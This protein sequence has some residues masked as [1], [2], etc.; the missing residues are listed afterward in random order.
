MSKVASRSVA[1]FLVFLSLVVGLVG[2]TRGGDGG[3]TKVKLAFRIVDA[4]TGR[5]VP[6]ADVQIR[7]L[8]DN[9]SDL[10]Y[11]LPLI[12]GSTGKDGKVVLHGEFKTSQ[13]LK[14]APWRQRVQFDHRWLS[15]KALGYQHS[16]HLLDSFTGESRGILQKDPAEAT[17]KLEPGETPDSGLETIAD[18]YRNEPTSLH[19]T[20]S[21]WLFGDG[22]FA[23]ALPGDMGTSG[24]LHWGGA[25]FQ[26][27]MVEL[28][29]MGTVG[30]A[31]AKL[32][33]EDARFIPVAWG[34]RHYLIEPFRMPMFCNE[35]NMGTLMRPG[36]TSLYLYK[37]SEQDGRKVH[38]G[39]PVL[40]T[41][42]DSWI[43]KSPI[44]GLVLEV[45]GPSSA[46]VNLGVKNGVWKGMLLCFLDTDKKAY[47]TLAVESVTDSTCIAGSEAANQ[48][49][50]S[51][52]KRD[53]HEDIERFESPRVGQEVV[54]RPPDDAIERSNFVLKPLPKTRPTL[55]GRGRK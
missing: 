46:R 45:L 48:H 17:I 41:P 14:L 2:S 43:L 47:Y 20:H 38:Y 35:V 16:F 13:D 30:D 18:Y 25:R 4:K 1:G 29:R 21:L 54:S 50:S 32:E 9:G 24:G 53:F 37:K 36:M 34:E 3:G 39:T 6:K 23:M 28:Q 40:P 55:G 19:G 22:R 33:P 10:K 42:F 7:H 5:P 15:V 31:K 52:F 26:D 51:A 49:E 12:E 27:G 11:A 8:L 44:K